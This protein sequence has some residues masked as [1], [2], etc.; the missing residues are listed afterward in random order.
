MAFFFIWRKAASL[1]RAL[2]SSLRAHVTMTK[3]ERDRRSPNVTYSAPRAAAGGGG[4][5]GGGSAHGRPGI[6][7]QTIEVSGQ[8]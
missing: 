8:Q 7:C 1:K 6:R 5:G 2:V 4:G 3:S